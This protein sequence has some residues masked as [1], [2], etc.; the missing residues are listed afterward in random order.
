MDDVDDDWM[1]MV[2]QRLEQ[3][4]ISESRFGRRSNPSKRFA[5]SRHLRMHARAPLKPRQAPEHSV[6]DE[7]VRV[8]YVLY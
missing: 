5:T 6:A 8:I 1:T 3:A 7:G 4:V 2:R